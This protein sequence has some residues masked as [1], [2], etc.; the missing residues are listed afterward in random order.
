MLLAGWEVRIGKNSERG[1]GGLENAALGLR[2]HFQARGHSFSR[3]G[4]TLRAYLHG[5]WGPQVGE[6]TRLGGVTR[7]SI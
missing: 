6:V 4:P 1:L 5:V 2:Q 3:Y 7:L